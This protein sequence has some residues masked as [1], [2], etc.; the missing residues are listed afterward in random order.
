VAWT[1]YAHFTHYEGASIVRK[2]ADPQE[3]ALFHERWDADYRVDPYY[4]P[5]LNQNLLRTYEAL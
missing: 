2:K 3:S 1:P 4:S 5:A